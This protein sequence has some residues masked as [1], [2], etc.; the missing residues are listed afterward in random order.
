MRRF[1][2]RLRAEGFRCDENDRGNATPQRWQRQGLKVDFLIPPSTDA[3]QKPRIKHLE[4]DFAA[5]VMPGLELAFVDVHRVELTGPTLT[6]EM[7]TRTV[8]VCGSA[9]YVVLKANALHLR[10]EPKDAYD[11]CYVLWRAPEGVAAIAARL[12][13]LE[14]LD[15]TGVASAVERLRSDFV[16]M[17]ALGPQRAADFSVA[18]DD[19]RDALLADSFGLVADLL[20]AYDAH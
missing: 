11:L 18:D 15:P 9:A 6:G 4:H 2:E 10:G 7:V 5:V 8:N 20:G 17:D 1:S 3:A 12:R 19:E 13:Q 14:N 16:S